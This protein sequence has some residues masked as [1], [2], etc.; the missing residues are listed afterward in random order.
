MVHSK[1][2]HLSL[3]SLFV[4]DSKFSRDPLNGDFFQIGHDVGMPNVICFTLPS[5]GRCVVQV[6]SLNVQT[7]CPGL[8]IVDFTTTKRSSSS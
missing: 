6:P 8:R 4:S 1:H 2:H 7:K 5:N 3:I